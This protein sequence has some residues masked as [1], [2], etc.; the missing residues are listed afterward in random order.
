LE[1]LSFF[2]ESGDMRGVGHPDLP[3]TI[4][5]ANIRQ[6]FGQFPILPQALLKTDR[7]GYEDLAIVWK[8]AIAEYGETDSSSRSGTCFLM[9][10]E[11]PRST[12]VVVEARSRAQR[13]FAS[14]SRSADWKKDYIGFWCGLC[15]FLLSEL[16]LCKSL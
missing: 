11:S 12:P 15:V 13:A 1:V 10:S 8:M 2:C 9:G 16:I 3:K 14:L 5:R 4:N 6:L 7:W